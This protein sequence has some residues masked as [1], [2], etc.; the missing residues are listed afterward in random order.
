MYAYQKNDWL[1]WIDQL[2]EQ[3]FVVI[4]QAISPEFLQQL[5]QPFELDLHEG[6]RFREAGIGTGTL[7]HRNTKRRG[8]WV[9]WLDRQRD[10]SFQGFFEWMDNWRAQLN[11]Y[12]FLSL[13]DAE[14]HLAYYPP[15]SFYERHLDQFQGRDNRLIS[16]VLYLNQ[17]WKPED[18]GQL[19]LF[20][21]DGTTKDVA[22]ESCR[23]VLFRS[24]TLEHEV[25]PTH[26]GRH[27]L[28]GWLLRQPATL[29]ALRI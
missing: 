19:R 4:D 26:S 23:L 9:Y 28:T 13:S 3:D 27:S 1:E 8:D 18:G 29:G 11:R 25:L 20:L 5:R 14:F 6:E 24:D 12:C 10:K 7:H 15:G 16:V 22:P 2:A 17:S 21:P